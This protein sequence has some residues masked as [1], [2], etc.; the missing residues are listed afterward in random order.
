MYYVVVKNLGRERCIHVSESDQY[1]DGMSFDCRLG[2]E[3]SKETFLRE[4]KIRCSSNPEELVLARLYR[5]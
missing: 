1:Q 5:D 4:L 2:F 3:Y